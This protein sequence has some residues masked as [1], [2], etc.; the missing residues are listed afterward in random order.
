[1]TTPEETTPEEK[2][3]EILEKCSR[4]NYIFRGENENYNKVS[5]GLYRQYCERDDEKPTNRSPL[6][7]NKNFF[8]SSIEQNIVEEARQHIRPGAL[9]IE[10]L[11]ELQHYGGKTALL[12]FSK[13]IY[14]ALFFACN[15]NFDENGRVIFFERSGLIKSTGIDY[16]QIEK[17][18]KKEKDEAKHTYILI[19]PTGKSPR[20]IFQSSIF[21]HT[22]RGCLEES[23][24][25]IIEIEKYL[26]QPLLS[27][28][29]EYF[30]IK[31]E[32]IYND[33]QGF[34]S[35]QYNH[36]AA[37]IAFYEG[38][39]NYALEKY[40]EAIEDYTRAI[41]LNLQYAGSYQYAEAYNN[42]G[43]ANFALKN[44]KEAIKD[45]EEAIRLNP[46]LAGFYQNCGDANYALKEYEKAIENYNKAIELDP[47]CAGFYNNRGNA[48]RA[49][50]N[51]KKAIT[52]FNKVIELDPQFSEG[53]SNRGN[54]NFDLKNYKKAIEDYDKAI[55]LDPQYAKAYLNRGNA[56]HALGKGNPKEAIK[57]YK[58]AIES[59]TE[60]K[61][62]FEKEENKEI[63]E[64]C[65][66]RIERLQTLI[67]REW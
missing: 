45:Y 22:P 32:T 15:G 28:L 60:A 64:T 1:M 52:D 42:R 47:Q 2:I 23:R 54:V 35:D 26:K 5:S 25:E 56:N 46:Q 57:Y 6:I 41:E 21:V 20:V 51:Y 62:L 66:K 29:S 40:E 24:Y 67:Y 8:V 65:E 7:D 19:S 31:T 30:N 48:N 55:E 49:L 58:R 39:A 53:Y 34:I 50:K 9:N 18:I 10:I 63:V 61:T 43:F 59:Y 12:D 11:T 13:N 37:K 36:P 38:N 4:G 33:I 44:Y 14:I 3:Q 27:Y 16:D 17:E